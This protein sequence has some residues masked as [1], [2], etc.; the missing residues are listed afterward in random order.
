MLLALAGIIVVTDQV[1]KALIGS[2][3]PVGTYA[4]GPAPAYAATP[5]AVIEGFFYMVHVTNE[6]AAWSL[7]DG[8]GR[9]LGALGFVAI[10]LIIAFRN[11]LELYRREVQVAF[12]LITGGIIG[13]MLDRLRFGHVV[14]FFDVHLGGLLQHLNADLAGYRFPAFNI[15]DSGITVGVA[16]FILISFLRKPREAATVADV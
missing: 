6:G 14:D 1:T 2:M 3:M 5:V 7:F 10:G 4:L 15:A 13:N 16:L 9:W 8:H 11:A 12:G